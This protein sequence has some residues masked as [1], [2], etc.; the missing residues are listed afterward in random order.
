M[1]ELELELRRLEARPGDVLVIRL[2]ERL[3]SP[4]A[5]PLMDT[6][7]ELRRLGF[8]VIV[9]VGEERVEALDDK[10]LAGVGLRRV[11]T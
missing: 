1:P 3:K 7:F 8:V 5:K 6:A 9:L 11:P 2:P 10:V 4:D